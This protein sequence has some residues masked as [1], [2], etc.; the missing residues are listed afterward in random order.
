MQL[1]YV[2]STKRFQGIANGV[3]VLNDHVIFI[4]GDLQQLTIVDDPQ[5]AYELCTE[6]V[7]DC[8]EPL[9]SLASSAEV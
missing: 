9:P 2:W 6:Y 1:Y 5:A 8:N 4:Q 7:P 3:L